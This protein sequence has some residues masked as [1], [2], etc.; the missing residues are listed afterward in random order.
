MGKGEPSYCISNGSSDYD[1]SS[2]QVIL[3][4][5]NLL[6]RFCDAL[7]NEYERKFLTWRSERDFGGQG[8][9]GCITTLTIIDFTSKL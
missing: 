4:D 6:N 5:G 1:R 2:S 9:L 7:Q 8:A 3:E